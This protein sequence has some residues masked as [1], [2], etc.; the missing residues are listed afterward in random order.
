MRAHRNVCPTSAF[1]GRGRAGVRRDLR[2]RHGMEAHLSEKVV[3]FS[4]HPGNGNGMRVARACARFGCSA[5]PS[6]T[7]LGY[8]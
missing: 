2:R 6:L 7:S 1:G 8:G 4:L 5:R 3:T